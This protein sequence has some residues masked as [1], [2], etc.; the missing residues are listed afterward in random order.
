MPDKLPEHDFY[1]P[2]RW[3]IPVLLVILLCVIVFMLVFNRADAQMPEPSQ[4][5]MILYPHYDGYVFECVTEL[6]YADGRQMA[7]DNTEG[8]TEIEQFKLEYQLIAVS[9]CNVDNIYRTADNQFFVWRFTEPGTDGHPNHI[10][11]VR[12]A[13]WIQGR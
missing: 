12:G 5:W 13:Y 10:H 2:P 6:P 3:L 9:A 7:W 1:N 8:F 11:P 4:H